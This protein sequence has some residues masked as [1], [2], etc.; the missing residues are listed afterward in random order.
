LNRWT[1]VGKAFNGALLGYVLINTCRKSKLSYLYLTAGCFFISSIL[2]IISNVLWNWQLFCNPEHFNTPLY[3]IKCPVI[4]G[5]NDRTFYN[6]I[7][8]SSSISYNFEVCT[9]YLAHW[10]FSFR[11]FEVAEMLGR[12]DKSNQ[13][14][15][16][17]RKITNKVS[18]SMTFLIIASYCVM[19][20]Y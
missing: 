17:A 13:M 5:T 6:Q 10:F 11:Y 19:S 1:I 3:N 9:Y 4:S 7:G 15:L 18:V 12:T 16:K 14:H 2:G 8:L 20:V